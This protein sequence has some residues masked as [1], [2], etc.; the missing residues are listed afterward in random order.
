MIERG[1]SPDGLKRFHLRRLPMRYADVYEVA[2]NG[3]A[4]Y[5]REKEKA[6]EY[7]R[8]QGCLRVSS[9]EQPAQPG[10][11]EEGDATVHREPDPPDGGR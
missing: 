10:L 1:I 3:A 6:Y 7:L 9:Q 11:P 4:V 8:N 2:V 5:Y